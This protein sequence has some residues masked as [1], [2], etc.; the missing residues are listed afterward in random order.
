LQLNIITPHSIL[1]LPVNILLE[2]VFASDNE[3]D[4]EFFLALDVIHATLPD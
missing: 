3:L 2:V 4:E 1:P